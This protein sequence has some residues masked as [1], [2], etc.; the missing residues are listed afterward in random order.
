MSISE[1]QIQKEG[2]LSFLKEKMLEGVSGAISA[3]PEKQLRCI[4]LLM[5]VVASIKELSGRSIG[6]G[7]II[8]FA[9]VSTFTF[10]GLFK[11]KKPYG[12]ENKDP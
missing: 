11:S 2:K 5:V 1:P 7:Y 6:W 8:L 12:G 3:S 4:L 9:I 10:V